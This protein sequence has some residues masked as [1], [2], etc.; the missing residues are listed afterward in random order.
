M[1]RALEE[2]SSYHLGRT[3]WPFSWAKQEQ[4][5]CDWFFFFFLT[6]PC[7]QR[8]GGEAWGKMCSKVHQAVLVPVLEHQRRVWTSVWISGT[9]VV[10]WFYIDLLSRLGCAFP[11]SVL[12][13]LSYSDVLH[14]WGQV[15]GKG[16]TLSYSPTSHG[17]ATSA[18]SESPPLRQNP[19]L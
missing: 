12:S 1:G 17:W 8:A 3:F 4:Q 18:P 16:N 9:R 13:L 11:P 10:R 6:S 14:S 5:S 2:Y 7:E 15:N 19:P